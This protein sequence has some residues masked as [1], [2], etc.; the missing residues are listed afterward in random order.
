MLRTGFRGR[1]GGQRL[2]LSQHRR[3]RAARL[4]RLQPDGRVA[5]QQPSSHRPRGESLDRRGAARQRGAGRAGACSRGEPR[6]QYRQTQSLQASPRRARVEESGQRSKIAQ[7]GAA[8]VR[9]A[10][11]LQR[12]VVV[13]LVEDRLHYLTVA[14]IRGLA[15]LTRRRVSG[16][17]SASDGYPSTAMVRSA[18]A[19]NDRSTCTMPSA[20]P[21]ARP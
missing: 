7:V 18:S 10:T 3:Q 20:P 8:G 4:R 14:E 17:R 1:H 19:N 13:E 5:G 21:S 6:P 9:R 12:Q 15:Q 2:V 16:V 11:T